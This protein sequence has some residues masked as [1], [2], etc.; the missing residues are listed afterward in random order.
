VKNKQAQIAVITEKARSDYY[1]LIDSR[2]PLNVELY[3]EKKGVT[4][5]PKN[6]LQNLMRIDAY[7]A[8]N[9]QTMYV[10]EERFFDKSGR[11][12]NRIRFSIAHEL[13]HKELHMIKLAVPQKFGIDDVIRFQDN[14]PV[15]LHGQLE[16]EAN[17]F[18]GS[19]LVPTNDLLYF[20]KKKIEDN[21]E[22]LRDNPSITVRQLLLAN[23]DL[24]GREFGV[25]G[26][27][28]EIRIRK[29]GVL[30]QLSVNDF[31]TYKELDLSLIPVFLRET[32]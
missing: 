16:D 20:C 13:G 30:E 31:T 3:A 17:E 6:G 25:S 18:A 5:V 1:G 23:S 21:L 9:G 8:F 27:V 24:I 15:K 26:Q 29:E 7:L 14:F 22:L 28:I 2:L 32:A 11:H 12:E 4:I 10:D 19:F